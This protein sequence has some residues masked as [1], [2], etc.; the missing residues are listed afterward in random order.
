[1]R[2]YRS[3]CILKGSS[4]TCLWLGTWGIHQGDGHVTCGGFFFGPTGYMLWPPGSRDWQNAGMGRWCNTG[5]RLGADPPPPR[6]IAGWS[7]A[8]T[9]EGE[10]SNVTTSYAGKGVVRYSW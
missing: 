10:L 3:R 9:F 2:G 5:A 8:A 1:V 7:A 6:W 4:T